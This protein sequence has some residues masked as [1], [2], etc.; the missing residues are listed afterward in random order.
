MLLHTSDSAKC[1]LT[2]AEARKVQSEAAGE[3]QRLDWAQEM[4][5]LN[6]QNDPGRK[7]M[8]ALI[9]AIQGSKGGESSGTKPVIAQKTAGHDSM[10]R[11]YNMNVAIDPRT[12]K[13]LGTPPKNMSFTDLQLKAHADKEFEGDM[14]AALQDLI[15]KGYSKVVVPK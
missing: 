6:D 9:D 3:A 5:G 1:L 7:R 14:K 8:Y 2:L 4:A 15:V 10:G 12:G 13:E 11:P